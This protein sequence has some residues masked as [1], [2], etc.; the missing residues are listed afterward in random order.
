MQVCDFN[1]NCVPLILTYISS[2]CHFGE[3]R[4]SEQHN[5]SKHVLVHVC[6]DKSV[7]KGDRYVRTKFGAVLLI[8]RQALGQ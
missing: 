8:S 4:F 3:L 1:F 2:L 5:R 6:I 7:T